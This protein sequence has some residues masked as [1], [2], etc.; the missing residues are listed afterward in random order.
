MSHAVSVGLLRS[1]LGFT[2]VSITDSLNGTAAALGV[3]ATSLAIKVAQAGTDLILLSGSESATSSALRACRRREGQHPA[4]RLE[5]SY[6]RI[7]ALKAGLTVPTADTTAPTPSA[8]RSRT[9]T[10]S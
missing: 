8:H 10:P 9:C 6:A 7:L 1:T 5:T 2:G 4:S 3:S